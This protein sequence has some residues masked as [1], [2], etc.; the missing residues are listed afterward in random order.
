M[1]F[2]LSLLTMTALWACTPQPADEAA[3]PPRAATAE[4]HSANACPAQAS[5]R[6][7]GYAIEASAVGASC[8]EAQAS[9]AILDPANGAELFRA[10]TV[11]AQNLALREARTPA[12]M[13]RALHA[14][15]TPAGAARDSTSDLPPWPAGADGPVSEAEEFP[16]YVEQGVARE[17]YESIRASDVQ[18]YCYVQGA[19]SEAC[20]WIENGA[21]SRIGVQTFPG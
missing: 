10:D 2:W 9:L 6:W 3:S 16:F 12:E 21:V 14:W 4:R 18:M 15:I 19:E 8:A 5:T 7:S 11:A 13:E 1:R 20:V 17:T